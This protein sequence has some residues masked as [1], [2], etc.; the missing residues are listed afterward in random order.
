MLGR[1]YVVLVANR[2]S[3]CFIRWLFYTAVTVYTNM[4]SVV[5]YTVVTNWGIEV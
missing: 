4:C 5:S 3:V 1:A 2:C